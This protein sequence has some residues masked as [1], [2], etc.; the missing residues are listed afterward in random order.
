METKLEY[1]LTN[2]YKAEMI[3]YLKAHPEDFE[4]AI[5]LALADYPGYSWRAAWLLWSC[6]EKNDPRV[7]KH[8]GKIIDVLPN[9]PAPQQRELLLVL[10]RLTPDKLQQGKLFDVCVSIWTNTFLQASVRYNAF[11]T[12]ARIADNHPGLARELI[13][14]SASPYSDSL[15]DTVKNCISKRI[16]SFNAADI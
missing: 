6:M 13:L 8:L 4:E 15:S 14:L 1:I 2:S 3:A 12:M 9:K 5:S 7:R 10:Q 16:A 11:R